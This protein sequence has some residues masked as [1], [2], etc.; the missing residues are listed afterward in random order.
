MKQNNLQKDTNYQNSLK[1]K[2]TSFI[3]IK[4]MCIYKAS[5][6][7]NAKPII[8]LMNSTKF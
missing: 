3:S 1:N 5:K 8:S 7:E 2:E 6:K 4:D